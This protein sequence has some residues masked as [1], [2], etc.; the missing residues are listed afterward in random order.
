MALKSPLSTCMSNSPIAIS[1][2]EDGKRFLLDSLEEME[3]F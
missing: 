3:S 2:K 1:N